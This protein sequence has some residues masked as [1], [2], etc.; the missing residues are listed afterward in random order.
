MKIG[1]LVFDTATKDIVLI[2]KNQPS[3]G[4]MTWDFEVVSGFDI[5]CVD[6]EE[7]SVLSE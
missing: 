6:K 3:H 5:Y 7:L 1:D 4:T 2:I